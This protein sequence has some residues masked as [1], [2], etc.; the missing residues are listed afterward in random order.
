VRFSTYTDYQSAPSTE[1]IGL[2]VLESTKRLLGWVNHSGSV[3]KITGADYAVISSISD[4]GVALTSVS[5][6]GAVTAGKYFNDRDNLTLYLR[7]SDSVNPNG[8]F[9]AMTQ[10]HFFSNVALN[11]PWDLGT[12]F[13]VEWLPSL[14]ETS[15]FGVEIDNVNQQGIAIEGQGSVKFANDL[16]FWRTRFDKLYF[17]NQRVRVYSWNRLL[18]I[19]Q[20][21]LIFSGRI[22]DKTYSK[23]AV[24]FSLRDYLGDLKAPVALTDLST[25]SGATL[26]SSLSKAKKRR[27]YGEVSGHRP[28]NI[29]A[30]TSGAWELT[31]TVAT[32]YWRVVAGANIIDFREVLAGTNLVATLTAGYYSSTDLAAEIKTQ[33]EAA[34]AGTYTVTYIS[35]TGKWSIDSTAAYFQIRW[36]SGPNT[37]STAATLLG[38]NTS[39]DSPSGDPSPVY[40]SDR[41]VHP[42]W[43][44]GTTTT[45]LSDL[46]PGDELRIEDQSDDVTIATVLDD[47]HLEISDELPESQTGLTYSVVPELPK[48]YVNREFLVAG[49]ALYQPSTTIT[50]PISSQFMRIA[51]TAGLRA[52]DAL[53]VNG[54][55]TAVT[56]VSGDV[57]KVA[58]SLV[59]VPE[60]GD[61][62]TRPAIS[63]VYLGDQLLT[64]NRDYTYSAS[65]AT[66]TLQETAEFNIAP[67]LK[68]TGTVS[69]SAASRTI[70][71]TGT[72]FTTELDSNSYVLGQAQT[73]WS[74][75]LSIE[76][77]TSA[78]LRAVPGYTDTVVTQARRPAIYVEGESVLSCDVLG[79]TE[80]GTTSGTFIKTG[81][82][83]VKHLLIEAGL[84]SA[85]DEASFTAAE[86]LA[87]QRIGMVIP[88]KLN[89]SKVPTVRDCINRVNQ[90][91]FASLIQSNDFGLV[92]SV[93]SPGRSSTMTRFREYD[94]INFAIKSS[95]DKIAKT[96]VIEYGFKE[97]DYATR[98][99]SNLEATHSNDAAEYLALATKEFRTQTILVDSTQAQIL[100]NRWAFILSVARSIVSIKTKLQ[101]ARLQINDRILLDHEKL[102]ERFG[103]TSRLKVGMVQ[104]AF[105]SVT[106][107]KIELEDLAGS[108]SR[109]A[110]ITPNDAAAFDAASDEDKI[111]YGYITDAYGMQDN[112]PETHGINLIW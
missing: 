65:A 95:S 82:Q 40:E 49:H 15:D 26:P 72:L 6:I 75:I 27:I 91:I 20:A 54:E 8:K 39:D 25:V 84:E 55:N 42:K 105:K 18:P 71:G 88:T 86:D 79:A 44:V 45:F 97:Y 5:S 94:V 92:C 47:T 107:S 7:T 23:D 67:T 50:E 111:Y 96:A 16:T 89:D 58:T 19:A 100:A 41:E 33:M 34:G 87:S 46:S 53:I 99:A 59:A 112:D 83:V 106:D 30:L 61:T 48:R 10:K 102:Y 62:V 109:C 3:Y 78:T 77:D 43:L 57:L 64:Q 24:T 74:R 21:K 85:I 29:S 80:E 31:G 9:L 101:G 38:F 28:S 60:V 93:L 110:V 1:K 70:T 11:A 69:F 22:Q 52:G 32:G 4:S 73:T 2:V 68:L 63:K 90:S 81:S 17:E 56:R 103:T 36:A 104:A 12:G 37:A 98:E 76:S 51:S 35:E 66:I 13:D 14:L 108:F